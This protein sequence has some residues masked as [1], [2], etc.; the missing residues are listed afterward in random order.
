VAND[1]VYLHELIDIVGQG[2]AAYNHHMTANFGRQ[3]REERGLWCVGVFSTVGST[4]RWPQS[5]NLWEYADGWEGVAEHFSFEYS[6]REHQDRS[7][8]AWWAE[9]AVLRSGGFDRLLIPAHYS[10]TL[11]EMLAD[12]VR[13]ECYYHETV[14][15]EPG[16][17]RRYL[18]LVEE[19]RLALA[20]MFG[21]RLVGAYRTALVHDSEAI[22]VWAVPTWHDWARWEVAQ[23]SDPN[24]S[25]W[26]GHLHGLVRDW[27]NKL[28]VASELSPIRTGEVL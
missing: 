22:L 13:G 23:E 18:E 11:A 14:A 1:R 7:L 25:I 8:A 10:P 16:G 9:A 19:H 20:A 5:T 27:R 6:N 3:A 28:L 12:E 17:A 24:V 21:W 2:R 26:R 15:L 4:E